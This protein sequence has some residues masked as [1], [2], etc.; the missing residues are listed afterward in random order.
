MVIAMGLFCAVVA[1]AAAA[2]CLKNGAGCQI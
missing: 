2:K 1:A